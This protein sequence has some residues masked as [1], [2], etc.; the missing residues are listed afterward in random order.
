[1]T[2]QIWSGGFWFRLWENGPG[3]QALHRCETPL[4]SERSGKLRFV[5]SWPSRWRF[6]VLR[7]ERAY[8]RPD[9]ILDVEAGPPVPHAESV[10]V[11]EAYLRAATNPDTLKYWGY[12]LTDGR[13]V[14]H[15]PFKE[16]P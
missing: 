8:Q 14:R 13:T 9:G 6:R 11:R 10:L 7:W 2:G 3:L 1:M 12:R 15:K 5:P 4:Y 16:I